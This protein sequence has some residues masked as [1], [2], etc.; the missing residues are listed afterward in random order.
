MTPR[1][2]PECPG[3]PDRRGFLKAAGAAA[4]L[5]AVPRAGAAPTPKS[6]S[7]T[8][9][10]ALYESLTPDQKKAICFDWDHVDPKRKMK[11]REV[12]SANWQITPHVIRGPFYTKK[13]QHLIHDVFTGLIHPDWRARYEREIKDDCKGPFGISH[14]VAIFGK[15]GD[16]PFQMVLTGRHMTL[17]ADG[18]STAGMAFGGPIFY[19]HAGLNDI[20]EP[21]HPENVFW[22]QA[23]AANALYQMLDGRQREQALRSGKRPPENMKAIEFRPE[24]EGVSVATFSADQKEQLKKTLTALIEPFRVEDRDEVLAGIDKTG[25]LDRCSLTF[26]RDGDIGDDGVWDNWKLEGPRFCWWFRGQ[27]HVHVWVN[28]GGV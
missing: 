2:C 22:P 25:G 8:A 19:G 21:H 20:E 18:N 16:G 12:V 6:S 23:V 14:A 27:P 24:P 10:A 3:E 1:E 15:P 4:A 11:L 26:Y 9:V 7:E 28:A 13:Q 17:R 5:W